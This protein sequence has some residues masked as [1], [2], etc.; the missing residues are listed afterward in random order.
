MKVRDAFYTSLVFEDQYQILCGF[1]ISLFLSRKR[2]RNSSFLKSWD[3]KGLNETYWRIQPIFIG[4]SFEL[5]WVWVTRKSFLFWNFIED[6]IEPLCLIRDWLVQCCLQLLGHETIWF[7]VEMDVSLIILE[8]TVISLR[9][10][11]L[12]GNMSLLIFSVF[13]NIQVLSVELT[14]NCSTVRIRK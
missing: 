8:D 3:H 11:Y 10:L 14:S 4:Q 5:L 2:A 12:F 7:R 13:N 1:H 6:P 9:Y